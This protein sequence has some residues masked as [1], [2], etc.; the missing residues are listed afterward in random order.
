MFR[1]TC[2][3]KRHKRKLISSRPL[4][5]ARFCAQCNL[6][7]SA[8]NGEIWLESSIFG[9]RWKYFGCMNGGVYDITDWGVCQRGNLID[10]QPDGH[11]ILYKFDI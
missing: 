8:R 1:C 5:A 3:G 2:C 6:H 7:H 4:Y 10:M 9:L 11:Y